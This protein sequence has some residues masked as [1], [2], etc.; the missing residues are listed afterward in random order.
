MGAVNGSIA[1]HRAKPHGAEGPPP[2]EN[3]YRLFLLEVAKTRCSTTWTIPGSVSAAWPLLCP[4]CAIKR[5]ERWWCR[6]KTRRVWECLYW[7]RKSKFPYV[8]LFPPIFFSFFPFSFSLY[9]VGWPCVPPNSRFFRVR[10]FS[11]SSALVLSLRYA[12][13]RRS[14]PHLSFI[15]DDCATAA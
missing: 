3:S 10:L 15:L 11:V 12:H 1:G 8:P 2:K 7:G 9:D 14:T 13:M 5:S 4:C 6:K